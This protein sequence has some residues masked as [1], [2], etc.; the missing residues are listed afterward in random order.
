MCPM[1]SLE[2]T[3]SKGLASSGMLNFSNRTEQKEVFLKINVSPGSVKVWPSVNRRGSPAACPGNV[4][5]LGVKTASE[6]ADEI[7]LGCRES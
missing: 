5:L 6:H 2:Q 1:K 7:L 4:K 3:I